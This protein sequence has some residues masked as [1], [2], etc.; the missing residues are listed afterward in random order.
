M[1]NI[2]N[3]IRWQHFLHKPQY[4]GCKITNC[5]TICMVSTSV[6]EKSERS[7]RMS[8]GPAIR[9][10]KQPSV[11][12]GELMGRFENSSWSRK[13]FPK[14]VVG[15]HKQLSLRTQGSGEVKLLWIWKVLSQPFFQNRAPHWG[16]FLEAASKLRW[17][18]TAQLQ[19]KEKNRVRNTT[20]K[21][22]IKT[23]KSTFNH[24]SF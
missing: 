14:T 8:A 7:K 4:S 12:K 13:A 11:H 16:E 1:Y 9:T 20:W 15:E 22:K 17:K 3:K 5:H 2:Y 6:Q 19:L 24:A 18:E 21:Q 23:R 10:P